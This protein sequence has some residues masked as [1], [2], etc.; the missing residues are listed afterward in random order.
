MN[1]KT[2]NNILSFTINSSRKWN[3][4][5]TYTEMMLLFCIQAAIKKADSTV[6][7][8]CLSLSLTHA[9]RSKLRIWTVNS[10][11]LKQSYD[12]ISSLAFS[13]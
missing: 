10:K 8:P 12:A 5:V 2:V 13:L 11:Y 3:S 9:Q 6:M 4:R 7:W 1:V